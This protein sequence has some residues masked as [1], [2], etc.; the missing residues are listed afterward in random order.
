MNR[1]FPLA[2]A[3]VTA[4]SSSTGPGAVGHPTG[5]AFAR[6]G[7]PGEP[8]GVAVSSSGDVLV[9]QPLGN[10][11]TEYR[12]PDTLP[13][14]ANFFAGIEPAGVAINAAGTRAYIVTQTGLSLRVMRINP[15]GMIDSLPLT[16]VG[17][18]VALG[19]SGERV[20]VSTGDGRVYVVA[21]A[22][23]A[24]VDSMQAGVAANGL[25]FSPD[26]SKLYVSSRNAG[27]I[28]VFNTQTDAPIDTIV[29]GG[30]PQRIA[31]SLDGT[32]LFVAN[33]LHGVDVVS[34]PSGTLQPGIALDSTAFGVAITP[35]GKQLY[36]T[37]ARDGYVFILDVATRTWI[38]SLSVGGEPRNVAF[39]HDGRTAIITDG[40]AA[41]GRVIFVH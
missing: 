39:D 19:P 2:V 8:W 12:L 32:T 33:E 20:Y 21:T 38:K 34:L 27:T 18:D 35:D 6:P 25:A 7:L 3:L 22:T 14:T 17:Y 40:S 10:T 9:T 30:A 16:N 1:A 5:T 36:G 23:D 11:I 29:T 31:V 28:T 37:D 13:T 4:C 15:L 41:N 24:I 26:G